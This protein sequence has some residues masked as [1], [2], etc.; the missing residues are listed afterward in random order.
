SRLSVVPP[1]DGAHSLENRPASSSSSLLQKKI[2]QR[3]NNVL[4]NM[5]REARKRPH[6]VKE[7]QCVIS[8][9]MKGDLSMFFRSD[10]V[11]GAAVAYHLRASTDMSETAIREIFSIM[12]DNQLNNKQAALLIRKVITDLEDSSLAGTKIVLTQFIMNT[13]D[14]FRPARGATR[15]DLTPDTTPQGSKKGLAQKKK[16]S[17][18]IRSPSRQ[19]IYSRSPLTSR[20]SVKNTDSFKKSSSLKVVNATSSSSLNRLNTSRSVSSSG[21]DNQKVV[22]M[23]DLTMTVSKKEYDSIVVEARTSGS[24]VG[25]AL[26]LKAECAEVAEG[27][28]LLQGLTSTGLEAL[29][30]YDMLFDQEFGDEDMTALTKFW[31][32]RKA[33]SEDGESDPLSGRPSTD[34]SSDSYGLDGQGGPRSKSHGSGGSHGRSPKDSDGRYSPGRD[35]G[36]SGGKSTKDGDDRY[37]GA[38]KSSGGTGGSRGYGEDGEESE[39]RDMFDDNKSVS[40]QEED[41]DDPEAAVRREK[42]EEWEKFLKAK[43]VDFRS[44]PDRPRT[45]IALDQG[46]EIQ[47]YMEAKGINRIFEHL[48]VE[49]VINQP[50]K[51]IDYLIKLTRIMNKINTKSENIEASWQDNE[52]SSLSTVSKAQS[53]K[54]RGTSVSDIGS[55]LSTESSKDETLPPVDA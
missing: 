11:C 42:Q 2:S 4:D 35:S 15:N 6:E 9:P 38:S 37:S 28:I 41:V 50:P 3:W 24:V 54:G 55:T 32:I 46:P 21:V 16:R 26:N 45:P 12:R 30:Q 8:P 10:D 18:S 25:H 33:R 52:S 53:G 51:P 39:L 29:S 47:K 23:G 14:P 1:D 22:I 27:V 48:L 20:V 17:P 36:T 5:Q 43:P 13:R 19:S 34:G 49:L 44:L 7:S 40:W 31:A